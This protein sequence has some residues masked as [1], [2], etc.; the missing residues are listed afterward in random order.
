MIPSSSSPSRL[1]ARRGASSFSL[2]PSAAAAAAV[3]SS[4][5]RRCAEAFACSAAGCRSARGF[6]SSSMTSSLV[7]SAM[8]RS[9]GRATAPRVVCHVSRF[10]LFARCDISPRT[11]LRSSRE[12]S[13]LT[14][15]R[16]RE[17]DEQEEP[18]PFSPPRVP[19]FPI[20]F[21]LEHFLRPFFSPS[22]SC[23]SCS[24]SSSSPSSSSSSSPNNAHDPP[25][26][27]RQRAV[28]GPLRQDRREGPVGQ[29]QP[30]LVRRLR[31]DRRGPGGRALVL[32]RG[33]GRR[34]DRQ[35]GL[36]VRY[37]DL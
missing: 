9:R 3:A 37:A 11:A 34:D 21:N 22:S 16:E 24:S 6:G 2:R 7:S 26:R 5:G 15:R 8:A 13:R 4:T 35:V 28:R 32:P 10:Y 23:S 20:P 29:P 18:S 19:E 30:A 27:E 36:R 25:G 33:S 17:R 31:R 1:A 12:N 14:E